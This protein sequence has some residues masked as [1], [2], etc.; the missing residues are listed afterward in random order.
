MR[1]EPGT[2]ARRALR[3]RT[4]VVVQKYG[5]SSVA[6][7]EK[8]SRVAAKIAATREAGAQVAV[9][10][11]AMGGKTDEL[12]QLAARMSDSPPA[13][14]LDALLSAGER[15]STALLAMALEKRGVPAVSL[16]GRQCGIL[17]DAEHGRAQIVDV[18]A[19]RVQDELSSGRVP[20]VAGF[21][22]ISDSGEITTLGR[23]GSDT[24]ATAL[25]A[26]LGARHCDIFSDV[27]GVYTTD[28]R[29]CSDARRVNE[30]GY[31]TMIALARQGA[32]VLNPRA[33]EHAREGG[34][35]IRAGSTFGGSGKTVVGADDGVVSI[36]NGGARA[37]AGRRDLIRAVVRD[38]V[39]AR[40]LERELGERVP[41]L[42]RRTRAHS[43]ELYLVT[44]ELPDAE[45]FASWLR[46][47]DG[48]SSAETGVGSVA[49]VGA[50]IEDR[51]D[52]S[53]LVTSALSRARVPVHSVFRSS[54]A[55]TSIVDAT[56]YADAVRALHGA[57]IT[58]RA[59]G[60]EPI[61]CAG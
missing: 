57:A 47:Q 3:S 20:V 16:D 40:R 7:P 26:A 56:R 34:V 37:V 8:I 53:D 17:T 52:A 33:V 55:I 22:G 36:G 44:E 10:V 12:V 59:G 4:R 38:S 5:G 23:G 14:E 32:K 46:A 19:E 25:A 54:H 11:S 41:V 24:T 49:L 43:I 61:S 30:L 58:A 2:G 13:R 18:R 28:P 9:V 27:D 35:V 48:V 50:G 29:I 42:G 45:A 31:E 1:E 15:V 6:S 51:D 21:Q 39:C 60:E